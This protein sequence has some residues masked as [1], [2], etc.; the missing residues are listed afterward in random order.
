M[1]REGPRTNSNFPKMLPMGD[2]SLMSLT[3]PSFM[4][5]WIVIGL[6]VAVLC[7]AALVMP[8]R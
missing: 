5:L 8:P 7:S 4:S 6:I 1:K 3:H 2:N